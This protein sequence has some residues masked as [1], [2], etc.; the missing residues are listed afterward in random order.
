ML[1]LDHT[2]KFNYFIFW[3]KRVDSTINYAKITFLLAFTLLF[4]NLGLSQQ[5]S[6]LDGDKEVVKQ[7]LN[8]GLNL[9]IRGIQIIGFIIAV[10]QGSMAS[11][12]YQRSKGQPAKKEEAL[13]TLKVSVVGAIG[14]VIIPEL[15]KTLLAPYVIGWFLS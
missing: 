11:I 12:D 15:L 2:K 1:F 4:V 10:G 7:K 14:V 8:D 6:T 13:N 3:C 5:S 9:V